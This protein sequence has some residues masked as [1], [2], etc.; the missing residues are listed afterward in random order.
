MYPKALSMCHLQLKFKVLGRN[1]LLKTYGRKYRGAK[2]NNKLTKLLLRSDDHSEM[3]LLCIL[4]K[5]KK[6]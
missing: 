6:H 4:L 5:G 1:L 3:K 2:E